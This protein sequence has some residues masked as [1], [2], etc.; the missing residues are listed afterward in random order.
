MSRA[1]NDDAPPGLRHS[2][3]AGVRFIG[4]L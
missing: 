4:R 3:S 2:D 1:T